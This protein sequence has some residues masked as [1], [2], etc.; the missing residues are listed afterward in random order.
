MKNNILT[1]IF[2]VLF[3]A[4][5]SAQV[6]QPHSFGKGQTPDQPIPDFARTGSV[7]NPN[8]APFLHGVASGDPLSDRVIIW[9]R[10]TLDS[11]NQNDV[12]VNWRVATDPLLQD[13]V[14]TGTFT[15]GPNRDY[16]VKVDVTGLEAGSTYYYGF[17]YENTASLTGKTKTTP[18]ESIDHLKFGVVSCSNYQAGYFNGYGGLAARTDLDAVIHLGD[19]IYEYANFVY[20]ASDIWEDRVIAP[21]Q[22]IVSLD[23]YRLRYS[24]YRLDSNLARMHQ[25]HP[26]LAIWDD[27]ETANDSYQDGASN[28]NP[29]TEGEW[30]VRKAAAK[31]AYFEWLPVREQENDQVYRSLQY[32]DLVDLILL[33]TR[34]EGRE[35]QINDVTDP[36]LYAPDRTILGEA[37][38]AWLKTKLSDSEARWKV[39][40][41]QVIFSEFNV[42]WGALLDT[43]TSFQAL[44]SIFLDIWDGYPAERAELINYIDTN[45]IDNVVVLTGDFH[46]SFAFDV[47]AAPVDLQFVNVPG[48]GTLPFYNTSATY[49]PATGNGSIAVEFATPSITSANFDEN[50]GP[51]AGALQS[52]INN[53]I[54]PSPAL[55]LGNPNPHMKFVD[56]VQHGYFILDLKPDSTQA[57]Y[58]YSPILEATNTENFAAGYRAL[59]GENHLGGS[60]EATAPKAE[61]DVAAPNNPPVLTSINELSI[62][63]I[64]PLKVFPN[65]ASEQLYLS[66]ALNTSLKLQLEITDINGRLLRS[67]PAYDL[68]AGVQ[69]VA[70]DVKDLT[71]GTYI[72]RA[73]GNDAMAVK[74]LVK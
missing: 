46:S 18:V 73:T 9:T 34:L 22:E 59:D 55:S 36:A 13:T 50:V 1:T 64:R 30:E 48:I 41:Q 21:D 56:L 44:E 28:H 33:D 71:K 49:D 62:S 66:V 27:H 69:T 43:S 37:Q 35:Q 52:Q 11:L 39:V 25:Q 20:G 57:D 42:G 58:F 53:P 32:G 16:T 26:V 15:T 67:L 3:M 19:Y 14:V 23:D 4:G 65:P 31:K 72:L 8:W 24:T 54:Q 60:F 61:Q 29:A 47:T 38:K 10:I 63:N 6:N 51:A 45:D 40:A 5:L 17:T 2:C 12:D 70:I 74:F 7:F 68:P